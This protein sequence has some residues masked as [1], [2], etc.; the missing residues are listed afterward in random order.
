MKCH[1]IRQTFIS[2]LDN[3]ATPLEQLQIREHLAECADCRAEMAI[4]A[5]LQSRLRSSLKAEAAQVEPSPQA[6]AR[7]QARLSACPIDLPDC[8]KG[9]MARLGLLRSDHQTEY[10]EG[11]SSS[12]TDQ[13]WSFIAEPLNPRQRL[14]WTT[15]WPAR[16]KAH[17]RS[18]RELIVKNKPEDDLL[19]VTSEK[20][21]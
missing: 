10:K 6:W 20:G 21:N 2:Y 17:R 8:R 15:R 5:R 11:A 7:L 18:K 12:N 19:D 1:D 9:L 16:G 3:E 13:D 4:L 14:V